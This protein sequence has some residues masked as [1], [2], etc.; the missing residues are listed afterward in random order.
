MYS[1]YNGVCFFS[2][3]HQYILGSKITPIFDIGICADKKSI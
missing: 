2:V 1:I 3:S